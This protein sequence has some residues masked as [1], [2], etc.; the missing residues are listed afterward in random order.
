MG[1]PEAHL[2]LIPLGVTCSYQLTGRDGTVTIRPSAFPEVTILA[3]TAF[4]ILIRRL[5][6]SSG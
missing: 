4:L 2:S 3:C 5:R 6:R 1:R